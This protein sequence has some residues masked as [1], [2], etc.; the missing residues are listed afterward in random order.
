MVLE[1]ILVLVISNKKDQDEVHKRVIFVSTNLKDLLNL[2]EN[3]LE[4]FLEVLSNKILRYFLCIFIIIIFYNLRIDE[5]IISTLE[6]PEYGM[7]SGLAKVAKKCGEKNSNKI[8]SIT[9]GFSV[10]LAFLLLLKVTSTYT[11]PSP[12][13]L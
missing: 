3:I 12:M 9:P 4:W 8:S 5:G 7:L 2:W 11:Y 1:T 10:L 6:Y 13:L